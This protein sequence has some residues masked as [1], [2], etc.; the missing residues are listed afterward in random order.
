MERCRDGDVLAFRDLYERYKRPL[1]SLATRFHGNTLD[2]EDSLQEAFIR[3]YRG[4]PEFRFESR[5]E[6]W[7]Y[8]IVMNT[9]I[10]RTRARRNTEEQL[11]ADSTDSLPASVTDEGDVLLRNILEREITALPPQQR[12]HFP[13][14]CR[15]RSNTS[16]HRRIAG[17]SVG[18]SKSAYHRARE[19]L[20]ERLAQH[21]IQQSE[22]L[23]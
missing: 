23:S 14:V 6:T 12:A 22:T 7:L 2:A 15:A 20:K 3:V 1:F 21:G 4:L 17:I 13:H 16:R 10:G 9:C 18:A 8:R 19:A 11:D 5:L